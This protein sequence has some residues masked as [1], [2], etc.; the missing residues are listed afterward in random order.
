MRALGGRYQRSGSLIRQGVKF[1]VVGLAGVVIVVAG[2]DVLHYAA[3]LG[4]Y[5]S[6]TIATVA[7]M[8]PNFAANRYWTFRHSEA[9]L[10]WRE[11]ALFFALNGAGMV[12]Q[13]ACLGIVQAIP[14][15]GGRFWYT[16]ANF[17]GLALGAA[18]RFWSYRK[19]VWHGSPATGPGGLRAR[20]S[21]HSLP[22]ARRLMVSP[23]S[24][25]AAG[26]GR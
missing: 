8:I 14:G 12:C 11:T 3:G 10:T 18:F 25:T 7:G 23:A 20:S 26:S 2:A 6:V 9:H 17:L 24:Q 13:Y 1:A 21:S 19:W 22:A 16:M 4:Q 5:A 15:T